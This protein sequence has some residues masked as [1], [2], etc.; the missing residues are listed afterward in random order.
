MIAIIGHIEVDPEERDA[1]VASTVE[2]QLATRTDEPGCITYSMS[3][4]PADPGRIQIV[5]L[6]ESAATLDAHFQHP[7]FH[8]TGQAL[9]AVPRLGGSVTKYRIDAS[10]PVKGADGTAS[11]R[12]WSIEDAD[13]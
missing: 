9:R 1:L 4:D 13:P 6:W 10:D 5:E 11:A 2:L 8:A 7:N 12:F 3:A